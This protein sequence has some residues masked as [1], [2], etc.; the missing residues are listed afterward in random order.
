MYDTYVIKR[1]HCQRL[2]WRMQSGAYRHIAVHYIMRSSS[3]YPFSY[4]Y[5]HCDF[6]SSWVCLLCPQNVVVKMSPIFHLPKLDLSWCTE[7]VLSLLLL[8]L[9]LLLLFVIL[10]CLLYGHTISVHYIPVQGQVT[11]IYSKNFSVL[12]QLFLGTWPLNPDSSLRMQ[13]AEPL[14]CFLRFPLFN[15]FRSLYCLDVPKVG[16]PI[17][18]WSSYAN[19]IV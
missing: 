12:A 15:S 17:V 18:R 6:A 19:Q 5:S 16:S 11:S 9:L 13:T 7:N 14:I 1:R 4:C 3:S 10:C 2:I 8:L